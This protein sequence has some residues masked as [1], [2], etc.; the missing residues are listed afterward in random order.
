MSNET[1]QTNNYMKMRFNYTLMQCSIEVCLELQPCVELLIEAKMI[2]QNKLQI[3]KNNNIL[4]QVY[5]PKQAN[6]KFCQAVH[7]DSVKTF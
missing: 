1:Q 3:L 2:H 4:K 7:F 6:S 5:C